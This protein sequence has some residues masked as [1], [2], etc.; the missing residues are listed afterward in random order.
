MSGAPV[1]ESFSVTIKGKEKQ[2]HIKPN[3]F[4]DATLNAL[5]RIQKMK[6]REA[7]VEAL[8]DLSG[9][10][11]ERDHETYSEFQKE[12]IK[13]WVEPDFGGYLEAVDMLRTREGMATAL[14]MNCEQI[15]DI[16]HAYEII[17]AADSVVDIF[18]VIFMAGNEAVEA[19]KN[20][21]P[22]E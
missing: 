4:S 8:R 6:N 22:P 10:R 2:F 12:V 7:R 1:G 16:D 9:L 20:S 13:Q 3:V 21:V 14:L 11:P 5:A 19:A 17:G 15:K 18:N